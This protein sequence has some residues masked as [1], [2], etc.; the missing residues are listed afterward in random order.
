DVLLKQELA[1]FQPER[2]RIR[3]RRA[4][5]KCGTER[6]LHLERIAHASNLREVQASAFERQT[7]QRRQVS[8]LTDHRD[9]LCAASNTR[10]VCPN[11]QPSRVK[12]WRKTICGFPPLVSKTNLDRWKPR[13]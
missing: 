4:S 2:L 9:S 13:P 7:Q 5:G 6:F 12:S 3:R 10:L 11:G 1:D 8:F